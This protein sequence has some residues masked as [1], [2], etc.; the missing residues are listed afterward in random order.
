MMMMKT[1]M[2]S[3]LLCT[4]ESCQSS[5]Q[6]SIGLCCSPSACNRLDT[7]Q[8]SLSLWKHCK[9]LQKTISVHN[10][11][12]HPHLEHWWLKRQGGSDGLLVGVVSGGQRLRAKRIQHSGLSGFNIQH[13]GLSGFKIQHSGL[14]LLYSS[15]QGYEIIVRKGMIDAYKWRQFK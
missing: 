14:S 8:S 6:R 2:T 1:M 4:R 10:Y 11:D 7:D 12:F 13:S 3:D 5:C 9:T 15:R